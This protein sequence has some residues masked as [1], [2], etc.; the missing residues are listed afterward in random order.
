MWAEPAAAKLVVAA[1]VERRPAK[2]LQRAKPRC[3]REVERLLKSRALAESV[4]A[5]RTSSKRFPHDDRDHT[6]D[7]SAPERPQ[8]DEHLLL[9]PKLFCGVLLKT[10]YAGVGAS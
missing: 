9:A 1:E 6:N 3:E 5:S 2:A 7:G 10:G 8:H 4:V